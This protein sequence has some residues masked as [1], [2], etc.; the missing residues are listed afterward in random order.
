MSSKVKSRRLWTGFHTPRTRSGLFF[1]MSGLGSWL[2]SSTCC[3]TACHVAFSCDFSPV[4]FDH[5]MA[6]LRR[7]DVSYTDVVSS[8]W[9]SSVWCSNVACS[10]S[11]AHW[12]HVVGGFS[13]RTDGGLMGSRDRVAH[14]VLSCDFRRHN[15]ATVSHKVGGGDWCNSTDP[16]NW[17]Q[18][19]APEAEEIRSGLQN[20]SN[21]LQG[22]KPKTLDRVPHS[23][24]KIRSLFSNVRAGFLAFFEY[25]LR[26][27]V[28]RRFL[29]M[30]SSNSIIRL[31]SNKVF[32]R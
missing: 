28:P 26:R 8:S 17:Q 30:C 29:V 11:D 5:V 9:T 2:S 32:K 10:G 21:V 19:V 25:M 24:N 22:E 1:P 4:S 6:V 20:S 13:G 18:Q 7:L 23:E 27:C 12:F 16:T 15:M 14:R 31:A 3:G